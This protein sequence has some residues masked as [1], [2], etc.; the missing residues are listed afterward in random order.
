MQISRPPV[1]P[2]TIVP[3]KN[4]PP[5]PD[6]VTDLELV[7]APSA[8]FLEKRKSIIFDLATLQRPSVVVGW[9]TS[10]THRQVALEG[11]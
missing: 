6:E 11:R 9:A 7:D 2:P 3:F 8:I 4:C 1:I 10:Q 5:F